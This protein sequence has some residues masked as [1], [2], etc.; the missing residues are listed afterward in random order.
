MRFDF[1]HDIEVKRMM[2]HKAKHFVIL[3]SSV[4]SSFQPD[5]RN[6]SFVYGFA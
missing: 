4:V 2:A 6:R 3:E 5:I 1:D